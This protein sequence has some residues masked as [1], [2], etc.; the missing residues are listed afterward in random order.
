MD[1]DQVYWIWVYFKIEGVELLV[2]K[3]SGS[4]RF[5]TKV[6]PFLQRADMSFMNSVAGSICRAKCSNIL[7]DIFKIVTDSECVYTCQSL[8]S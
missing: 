2:Q 1:L 5:G 6:A 4:A 3:E 7:Q 8:M